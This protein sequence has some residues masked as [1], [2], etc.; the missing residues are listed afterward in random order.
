MGEEF[1]RRV[2]GIRRAIL[3]LLVALA[4]FSPGP[5]LAQG[6]T[7]GD[8]SLR[9]EYQYIGTGS[10]QADSFVADYWTTDSHIALISGD[11]ALSERW[12]VYAALPYVRKRFSPGIPDLAPARA[13]RT[14]QTATTGSISYH[15]TRDSGMTGTITAI[16]RTSPSASCT[17]PW[18]G[19]HGQCRRMSA[20]AFQPPITLSMPRQPL[21]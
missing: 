3:F 13:I 4:G 1:A 12:T 16:G 15:R 2:G 19:R 21:D 9:L 6:Q 11:Y 14:I 18:M 10:Y 8:A 20:M 17:R 7:R 5:V